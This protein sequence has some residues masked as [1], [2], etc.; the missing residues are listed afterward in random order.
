MRYSADQSKLTPEQQFDVVVWQLMNLSLITKPTS[1]LYLWWLIQFLTNIWEF[2][3]T[4]SFISFITWFRRVTYSAPSFTR[5]SEHLFPSFYFHESRRF[6]SLH[7]RYVKFCPVRLFFY[8]ITFS[9]TI[10]NISNLTRWLQWGVCTGFRWMGR[11]RPA[12]STDRH[13]TLLLTEEWR[14]RSGEVPSASV[15]ANVILS[16]EHTWAHLSAPLPPS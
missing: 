7:P 1:S 15:K 13:Q 9:L 6:F 12:G 2:I 5:L 16:P 3:F 11:V 8:Y 14:A 10:G 4:H